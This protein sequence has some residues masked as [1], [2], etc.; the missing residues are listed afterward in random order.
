MLTIFFRAVILYTVSVA[1]VRLMGK[2]QI[3]QLQPYEL[4]LAILIADLAAGPMS[5]AE[6]PLAYGLVPIAALVIMH[7]AASLLGM[8]SP[9]FRRLLNGTARVLILNGSIQYDELKRVCMTV[10]DLLEA[11]RANGVM[12][13]HEV[14]TA[15]LETNGTL[16][17]FPLSA[18]R[19][20]SPEDMNL[21]VPPDDPASVL[22]ADGERR[23]QTIA[24]AGLSDRQ[25]A[26]FLHAQGVG[27]P[28]SV[29]LLALDK[30][31]EAADVL[32]ELAQCAQL[33]EGQLALILRILGVALVSELAAQACRDAGE[34]GLALHV[35][36]G[37]KV[38]LLL[39]SAPL[40][41][42]LAGLVMELTA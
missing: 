13:I 18:K 28:R 15:V 34:E 36:T 14:G 5:G 3:G 29:L 31:G 9:P 39:L 38:I 26:D 6:T 8:K 37:A 40:L 42:Q 7:S 4:V 19:A 20:V 25:V 23:E 32:R 30:L 2:R 24:Q 1:A 17:V 35:E 11:V 33:Q 12:N 21:T 41:R 16:S 27:D 22:I 10:S